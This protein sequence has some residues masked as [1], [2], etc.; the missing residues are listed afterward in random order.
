MV[1]II[2]IEKLAIEVNVINRKKVLIVGAGPAGMMA[3]GFCAQNGADVTLIEKNELVGKKLRITGKGRCNITNACDENTFISNITS[4][5]KF[6]YSAINNFNSYDTIDFFEKHGMKVKI[7]RGNRAF[8][9]SDKAIDVVNVLKSFVKDCGC[10][11]LN[12]RAREILVDDGMCKGIITDR[13]EK[14]FSDAVIISTGG[15]SYPRTGSTGDGY[16]MAK[17]VGHSIENLQPS[18]VPLECKNNWCSELQGLSLRNV[19]IELIDNDLNKV[20]YKDFGEMIFTHFGVSGP[21]ILSASAHIKNINSKNYSIKIDLKP[22][23][24]QE[25][26]DKRLMKDFSKYINRDFGNSLGDL[27]PRKLIPIIVK[28]SGIPETLKCNQIT[29]DMRKNLVDILKGL[30]INIKDFRPIEEAIVTSGGIKTSEINPKTMESKIVKNLYFAGEVIDV[31]A[32]TG[33]FNLQI[34]FSTGYLAGIFAS[35]GD[36]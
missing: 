26:L 17:A 2:F 27:L 16:K 12:K 10:K 21:I 11:I 23:L 13:K 22:A 3:A 8:P 14:I 33:G 28:L 32:Y 24:T 19:Q 4:N 20:I 30:I 34:A 15:K 18:L 36:N 35:K 31:D 9:Q 5:G 25:Q 7:E 6:L 1:A 29:K